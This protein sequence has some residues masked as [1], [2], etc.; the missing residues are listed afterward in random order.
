MNILLEPK[1]LD[2]WLEDAVYVGVTDENFHEDGTR[3][4]AKIYSKGEKYY[5]LTVRNVHAY[6]EL[7]EVVRGE[8]TMT[9]T[10]WVAV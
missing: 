8:F 1:E 10:G 6:Y 7:Q 5:R 4:W 2:S 3:W 9:L